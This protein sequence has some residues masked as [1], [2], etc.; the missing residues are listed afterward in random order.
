MKE[1]INFVMFSCGHRG[2]RSLVTFERG[3]DWTRS[4]PATE[5]SLRRL[6]RVMR[7]LTFV[8]VWYIHPH[9]MGWS[10]HPVNKGREK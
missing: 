1:P 7:W 2:K 9:S 10:A 5:A 6:G 4:Y 3:T 8:E